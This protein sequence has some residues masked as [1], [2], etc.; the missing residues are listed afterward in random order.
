MGTRRLAL[1]LKALDLQRSAVPRPISQQIFGLPFIPRLTGR[2]SERNDKK[3]K[4][5]ESSLKNLTMLTVAW[6]FL[7]LI[8]M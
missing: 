4:L 1:A 2:R 8:N 7:L 5:S 6:R 3:S